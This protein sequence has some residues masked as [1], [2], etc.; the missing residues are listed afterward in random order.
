MLEQYQ[1]PFAPVEPPKNNNTAIL[2]LVFFTIAGICFYN[3]LKL[4]ND[5]KK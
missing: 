3:Y 2:A 5:A 4:E 1:F